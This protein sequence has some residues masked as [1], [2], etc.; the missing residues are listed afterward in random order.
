VT[1]P[2]EVDQELVGSLVAQLDARA[3]SRLGR[4]LAVFAVTTG[5]CG[6][7]L[8]EWT[9]LHHVARGLAAHGVM[10]VDSPVGADVL[11]V[12]GAMVRS[13]V[14]P[15]QRA[16]LAMAVPRWVVAV[17][18]CGVDGG[19]F[20]GSGPVAGGVAAAVPVN[21]VVPGCPPTPGAM[22]AALLAL[23]AANG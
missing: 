14:A 2:P 19:V 12:T 10:V 17:G 18:D 21:L 8:L 22:L 20:A 1:P 15:V 4:S 6:G 3:Q 16:L 9:M 5:D 11:L 13:L 23:V 7:C